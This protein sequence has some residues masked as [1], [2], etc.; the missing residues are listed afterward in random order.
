[1]GIGESGKS[2]FFLSN[3]IKKGEKFSFKNSFLFEKNGENDRQNFFLEGER[4]FP[5]GNGWKGKISDQQTRVKIPVVSPDYR[6]KV[7]SFQ[8]GY[9]DAPLSFSGSFSRERLVK[10]YRV[11]DYALSARMDKIQVTADFY[12][13]AFLKV[14]KRKSVG[15]LF[16]PE[17]GISFEPTERIAIFLEGNSSL[18]IPRFNQLYFEK[19]SVEVKEEILK[20][21][22]ERKIKLGVS[23]KI[24][25]GKIEVNFFKGDNEDLIIWS[26]RDRNGL[27]APANIRKANFWG[28]SIIFEKQYSR[29]FRQKFLYTYQE[30][31]NKDANIFRIPYYPKNSFENSFEIRAGRFVFEIIGKYQGREYEQENSAQKS[32]PRGLLEANIFYSLNKYAKIFLLGENLTDSNYEFVK[33]YSGDG[34]NIFGGVELKF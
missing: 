27:Y 17:L 3:E 26:D 22:Q 34:R 21:E 7:T 14:E 13:Y 31:E 8:I 19:N 4:F 25:Q 29:H 32:S 15:I 33:G 20:P 16:L 28:G 18:D 23:K 11:D 12:T 1:M 5:A 2:Q 6:N 24:N 9:Y 10:H 30:I